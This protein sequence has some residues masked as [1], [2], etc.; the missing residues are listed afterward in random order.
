[1]HNDDRLTMSQG[2]FF[3][4]TCFAL[5]AG[6]SFVFHDGGAPT[7]HAVFTAVSLTALAVSLYTFPFRAAADATAGD[8][9]VEAV[10]LAAGVLSPVAAVP[11][12]PESS[13]AMPPLSA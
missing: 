9:D 11:R 8:A 6:L 4:S 3:I 10:A 2:T 12:A 7:Q 5:L 1:M 13:Q